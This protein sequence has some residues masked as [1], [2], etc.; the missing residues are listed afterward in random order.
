MSEAKTLALITSG[1]DAPGMNTALHVLTERAEREG[2]RVLGVLEGF[3]GLLNGDFRTLN[4]TETV[5]YTRHGGTF[6]A[7]RGSPIFTH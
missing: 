1:G 3:Q 4:A 2:W 7:A 5:R 6:L